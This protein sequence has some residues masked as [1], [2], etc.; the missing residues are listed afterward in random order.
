MFTGYLIQLAE[1]VE[2]KP[3][4]WVRFPAS[5]GFFFFFFAHMEIFNSG[6]NFTT[7]FD[8]VKLIVSSIS[9]SHFQITYFL[10]KSIFLFSNVWFALIC[11]YGYL[12]NSYPLKKVC[13]TFII[14]VQGRTK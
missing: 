10:R 4:T 11:C 5:A 7:Q 12:Q 13:I 9:F 8:R 6:D 14:I 1:M 3:G 2:H